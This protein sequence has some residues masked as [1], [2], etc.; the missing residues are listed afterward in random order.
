[1]I[2]LIIN[3]LDSLHS[4]IDD[5]S[6]V[7]KRGNVCTFKFVVECFGSVPV[8]CFKKWELKF[9]WNLCESFKFVDAEINDKD[10]S[11]QCKSDEMPSEL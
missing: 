11:N 2:G 5:R 3:E 6:F 9:M 10:R 4:T 7:R 1:M 8:K